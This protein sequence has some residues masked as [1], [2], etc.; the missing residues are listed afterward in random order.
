MVGRWTARRR[1]TRKTRANKIYRAARPVYTAEYKRRCG[2]GGTR[3]AYEC[4][5]IVTGF[6]GAGCNWLQAAHLC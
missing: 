2:L 4:H 5:L 1:E 6:A 3:E